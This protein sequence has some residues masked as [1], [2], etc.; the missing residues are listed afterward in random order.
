MC[1]C[2]SFC[3]L[4]VFL[5]L[6]SSLFAFSLSCFACFPCYTI[7]IPVTTTTT[8]IIIMNNNFIVKLSQSKNNSNNI[9]VFFS[10][11]QSAL[12]P[13]KE[14][15]VLTLGASSCPADLYLPHTSL[16]VWQISCPWCDS[17]LSSSETNHSGCSY[18]PN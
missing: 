8:I 17:Y 15:P 1:T 16:V 9:N 7:V 11:A 18:F 2:F 3:L 5:I 4:S 14:V 10:A 12:A 6:F 13:R